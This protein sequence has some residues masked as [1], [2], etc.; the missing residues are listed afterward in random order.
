MIKNTLLL[1]SAAIFCSFSI[2]AQKD[3]KFTDEMKQE[4]CSKVKAAAQHAWKGY[5]D[6]AWGAD[7]LKPLTK[8]PKTW[9]NK[10]ML[11]T[12]VDAFDTFTLLGRR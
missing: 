4:M 8:E 7:D 12:P 6:H 3:A 5:K 2:H 9:Y 10:S 11:M 1:A